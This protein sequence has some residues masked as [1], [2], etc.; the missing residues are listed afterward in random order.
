[1]TTKRIHLIGRRIHCKAWAAALVLA[2]TSAH[3]LMIDGSHRSQ[4]VGIDVITY[5]TNVHDVVS[6]VGAL[7]AGD[8][9]AESDNIAVPTL[10]GMMLDRGTK[11]LDKFA[12]A[13]K[14]DSVGAEISFAVGV[15]SLE[16]RARC[17]KKDLPLVLS[18]IAAELRSPALS[19]EEF[20]KAKQQFV[21]SLQQ[22]LQN[23][24]LRAQE[25][26]GRAVFPDGH[27]NHPH[28]VDDYLSAAKTATLEEVKAFHARY[29]GP[30]A[31]TLVLAGDVAAEET[32]QEIAKDFSGWS[33]GRDYLRGASPARPSG[34]RQIAVPLSQKPSTSVILGQATGLRYRD[35]DALALRVGTAIL[36]QGFT[37]RLMGTVRDRE[38]LTY[39]IG[40]GMA[41]D[42]IADGEW[43]I[44][45]SFAPALLDKGI[46][47]TQ[48][49][50]GQWWQEGVTDAELGARK[51][52]LVG[53]YEVGLST[54]AGLANAI[55]VSVQR[56][57]DVGWL[58][59]Y[60]E[61]IKALTREQVNRA[62][63]T[64]LDPS[65]MVLVEAGSIGS[66][67]QP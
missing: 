34:A 4:I 56:G 63:H 27:P 11:T 50:L 16:I 29:Y 32:A 57:Y 31:F 3:G 65:A 40:A 42:S 21:G 51:K 45:A 66:A 49:V 30:R 61:A 28:A 52:G 54:S 7:P 9:M 41:E 22:S 67:P 13:E 55:L 6:V 25:A 2:A 12:I 53:S 36:G 17:L 15:Q 44:S 10:T 20:A 8:A 64:R 33:G 48:R 60:P 46:A 43:M 26:F 23:T 5:R 1:V 19:P 35:P 38:G 59:G 39:Q 62:I 14:L 58:D 18:L 37:G 24:A 47:S